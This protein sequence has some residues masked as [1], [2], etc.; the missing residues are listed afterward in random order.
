MRVIKTITISEEFPPKKKPSFFQKKNKEKEPEEDDSEETNQDESEE[1]EAGNSEKKS[2]DRKKMY[3]TNITE[4]TLGGQKYKGKSNPN[5]NHDSEIIKRIHQTT[6]A[7]AKSHKLPK[8]KKEFEIR[9]KAAGN[10]IK[11]IGER[12]KCA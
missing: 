8:L 6:G 9:H 4:A 10:V 5:I 12:K 1:D 11:N 3:G 2:C 7:F